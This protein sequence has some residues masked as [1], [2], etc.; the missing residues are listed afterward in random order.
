MNRGKRTLQACAWFCGL[1]ALLA[2][3][4]VR[5]SEAKKSNFQ[6]VA[7][8]GVSPQG[9]SPTVFTNQTI[10]MIA[11]PTVAGG[12]VRVRI[13]N[14][15]A[16]APLTIGSASIAY[17]NNGAQLVPGSSRPLTF[18]G[19]SSVTIPGGGGVYTDGLPF[20]ARAWEDVAV[21]LY[22]PGAGVQVSRHG[23]ARKTSYVT[24]PAA[25][26]HT[27]DEAAAAFTGTTVEMLLVAAIDV[28]SEADGAVVFLG[29]SITDGTGTTTDGHDRWHD[30]A[31]LRTL[32]GSN[33][34]PNRSF[35]NEGIGGNRVT[36]T[37]TQGSPAAVERLDRD[38]LARS[39]ITHVV[40]FE[41]TNDINS[42]L[43][44]GD[45]LIVGMKEI[46]RRVK[47]RHL[48][49]IG[50]T[51]IPRSSATWTPLKTQYRRQVNDWIRRDADFDAV[52]DFDKVMLDPSNPDRMAPH[53]D[54]G[55][56]THPNP[57]GYLL[58]GRSMNLAHLGI[59]SGGHG[60][61]D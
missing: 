15:F 47:A 26:D 43:V 12:F 39:G 5:S 4:V 34:A 58:I 14:T 10:R 41:G 45:Q 48:R 8:W 38:V 42:D 57:Y 59:D 20:V 1:I 60:D 44:T 2:I 16:T 9:L 53:L 30:V 56:G 52:Y 27:A 18:S 31:F 29:D 50:A 24:A 28:F 36:V 37:A 51:I 49:I 19:S 25:G 33:H 55:D 22:L 35:V 11:R 23:N 3:G 21:S 13:E 17:R 54:L 7:A 6:W 40:F 61:D 32:L 46:I